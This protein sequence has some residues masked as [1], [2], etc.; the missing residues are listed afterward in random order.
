MI[1]KEK[2]KNK[3]KIKQNKNQFPKIKQ[4]NNNLPIKAK[5]SNYK[6]IQDKKNNTDL[7]HLNINYQKEQILSKANLVIKNNNLSKN[8]NNNN[9]ANNKNRNKSSLKYLLK[10]YGLIEYHKKF[11]ELGYNN[12]NYIQIGGL[13]RRNF[14]SLINQINIVPFHYEK[15]EKFYYY[16]KKLNRNNNNSSN[17]KTKKKY[18]LEPISN[19]TPQFHKRRFNFNLSHSNNF[20]IINN[21]EN[22][23][24]NLI[25]NQY[26][27]YYNNYMKQNH[28]YNNNNIYSSDIYKNKFN[29]KSLNINR[30]NIDK[31][32][33]K[34][35]SRPRPHTS[36]PK[37]YLNKN[38]NIK[39]KI[40]H[41]YSGKKIMQKKL[42]N[43][44]LINNGYLSNSI[45]D[46]SS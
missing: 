30:G 32:Y 14:A 12:D 41:N 40:R 25:Y 13:S 2:S 17:N 1:I 36:N 33:K 43:F 16:L 26:Q 7:E 28:K 44:S 9:K 20:N 10:E 45:E 3:N 39:I 5:H 21:D 37:L 8:A 29:R 18:H 23:K 11:N 15:M 42:K 31:I 38:N 4:N 27:N 46:N 19:N 34:A 35:K 6:I 22:S 24:T